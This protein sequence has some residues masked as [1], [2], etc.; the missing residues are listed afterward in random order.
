MC[1][2][3]LGVIL[4]SA[5]NSVVKFADF[6]HQFSV[7][8]HR[9]QTDSLTTGDFHAVSMKDVSR[10]TRHP[11][12]AEEAYRC[13]LLRYF[14]ARARRHWRKYSESWSDCTPVQRL[15][16]RFLD[17]RVP[18]NDIV[19]R[20]A[21]SA[22][23]M[24]RRPYEI[25]SGARQRTEQLLA[26][27]RVFLALAVALL[28]YLEE[29][30]QLGASGGHTGLVGLYVL[31]SA[32]VL[33]LFRRRE[34]SAIFQALVHVGDVCWPLLL[35]VLAPTSHH[36][37]WLLWFFAI[38]AAACRWGPW[39]TVATTAVALIF[40]ISEASSHGLGMMTHSESLM[41][42]RDVTYR[43]AA[44]VLLFGILA[45][46]LARR[47]RQRR[48]H[49]QAIA[50]LVRIPSLKLGLSRTVHEIL[51][52]L[53]LLLGAREVLIA[54]DEISAGRSYLWRTRASNEAG[55]REA[56]VREFDASEKQCYLFTARPRC[57]DTVRSHS[58][59]RRTVIWDAQGR[60]KLSTP[61]PDMTSFVD[62]HPCERLIVI[63]FAFR[64]EWRG[65]V[66]VLDPA[67][68]RD[69]EGR[70]KFVEAAIRQLSPALYGAYLLR[71]VRSRSRALERAR[72]AQELHDGITQALIAAQMKLDLARR[73]VTAAPVQAVTDLESV[74]R[75]LQQEISNLRDSM[76]SLKTTRVPPTELVS[77]MAEY[78][79]RFEHETGITARLVSRDVDSIRLS[80]RTCTELARI[81]REALANV[82]RHSGARH[83]IVWFGA[84]ENRYH[85]IVEDDGRGME[86]A[87][88]HDPLAVVSGE[89]AHGSRGVTS[90]RSMANTATDDGWRQCAPPP[91][92]AESVMTIGAAVVVYSAPGAG[93][94][95]EVRVSAADMMKSLTESARAEVF[96]AVLLR[97]PTMARARL[98][99]RT[100]LSR[101]AQRFTEG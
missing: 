33:W 47:A 86:S 50:Q 35:A 73:K 42:E 9:C 101:L 92:I 32:L 1:F 25:S 59:G 56:H 34:P 71:R 48:A 26:V 49:R 62:R 88:D 31:Q 55:Q 16:Q 52:Q 65:R 90:I 76:R 97:K 57:W 8:P 30:F 45:A 94:R 3:G 79:G 4:E 84:V 87:S 51:N 37:F 99:G 10:I 23:P 83:V 36:A 46:Y 80:Q 40:V 91:S 70:L 20:F 44:Y 39:P 53:R 11:H 21:P 2:L 85:L 29:V 89:H 28:V 77:V 19:L 12:L 15:A 5:F 18:K 60:R 74:E 6:S 38:N 64:K 43:A 17:H 96:A 54:V 98:T 66:F 75:I 93:L 41:G 100:P 72:V 95:L 82:R 68:T 24:N 69:R 27:G 58:P 81:L 78:V 14:Q 7:A 13:V 61:E 67:P 63:G 22:P